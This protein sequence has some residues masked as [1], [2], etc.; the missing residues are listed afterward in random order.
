[1]HR[2]RRDAVTPP[3]HRPAALKP[4]LHLHARGFMT[5][6]RALCRVHPQRQLNVAGDAAQVS[7]AGETAPATAQYRTEN[8]PKDE[9]RK[10]GA[11]L[12]NVQPLTPAYV[13]QHAARRRRCPPHSATASAGFHAENVALASLAG[14]AS[15][16][17][18]GYVQ[19]RLL[20][21]AKSDGA[22]SFGMTRAAFLPFHS[23]CCACSR[24]GESMHRS[25]RPAGVPIS[26]SRG[27]GGA[28]A[29]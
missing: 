8:R 4:E 1:M 5:G 11:A 9:R 20:P 7:T 14:C 26:S 21:C 3:G 16:S 19:S 13:A 27:N 25:A 15:Y 6:S 12:Q 17:A 24:A 22:V 28:S 2:L 23:T 18:T 10:I 29:A